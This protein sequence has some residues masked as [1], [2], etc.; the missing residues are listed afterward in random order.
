MEAFMPVV[1]SLAYAFSRDTLGLRRTIEQ[2]A[3]LTADGFHYGNYLRLARGEYLRE[4]GDADAALAEIDAVA[5]DDHDTMLQIPA[6]PALAETLLAVGDHARAKEVAQRGV[7]LG[8]DPEKGNLLGELRSVRVLA[9]AEAA[10]GEDAVAARRLDEAIARATDPA[11]TY[12]SPLLIGS[13]HEARARVALAA[14]DSLAY[15]QHLAET[16]HQFR[17]TRNPVLIARAERLAEAGKRQA[18]RAPTSHDQ[19]R[20]VAVVAK[21]A[22]TTTPPAE[23][24]G[25]VSAVLSGC[26]GS[27]ERATR[28][29]QLVIGEAHG[30][31]G[32]LYLRHHG[33]LVLAAPTW[34]DEPPAELVKALARAVASPDEPATVA[35]VRRAGEKLEWKPVPLV[36]RLGDE[37]QFVVGGVAVIAGAMPLVDP[38]PR[39][40]EEIARELF[41]AGDVTHTRTHQ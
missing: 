26:R 19:P 13:L 32:Y 37:M 39:L 33:Q 41:E 15:H 11:H 12:P 21:D 34:G 27:G 35:D 9:L 31:S 16:E 22:V 40:L 36:M 25:W 30:M 29:L 8:A 14:G 6:L 38:D 10:L 3:R 2:L 4:R 1:S 17:G 7:A 18:S 24:K 23:A 28:V 20:E 5:K